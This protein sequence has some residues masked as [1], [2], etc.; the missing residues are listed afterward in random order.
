M[1]LNYLE[2][3]RQAN[4]IAVLLGS[5]VQIEYFFT[6]LRRNPNPP[7]SDSNLQG[8]TSRLAGNGQI[9]PLRHR[10]TSIQDNVE[11]TLLNE[12][13]IQAD[14][15]QPVVILNHDLNAALLG[16]SFC[17]VDHI[18]NNRLN[19]CFLKSNFNGPVEV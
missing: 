11:Q 8:P 7:V 3:S 9:S 6:V 10:L 15:W 5:I 1:Q 19:V 2:G 4:P 18:M 17:Q 13:T 16:L 12:I 14:G